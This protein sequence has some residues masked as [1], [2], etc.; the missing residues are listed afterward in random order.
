MSSTHRSSSPP[1]TPSSDTPQPDLRVG[2]TKEAKRERRREAHESTLA[3]LGR[4]L[5]HFYQM[6]GSSKAAL[7]QVFEV[8]DLE[9]DPLERR[10]GSS[11]FDPQ[12]ATLL[13]WMLSSC[14]SLS[15]M[16]EDAASDPD[17]SAA[18]SKLA[19]PIDQGWG[20]ARNT[21]TAALKSAVAANF[22][23]EPG[24]DE[25]GDWT[26]RL[27]VTGKDNWGL[28]HPQLSVLMTPVQDPPLTDED[29]AK[30]RQPGCLVPHD[31]WYPWMWKGRTVDPSDP[32][33]GFLR[34]DLLTKAWRVIYFG[35]A[36]VPMRHRIN[37]AKEM[38]FSRTTTHSIAYIATLM[39]FVL[40]NERR[41]DFGFDSLGFYRELLRFLRHPDQTEF[42]SNLLLWWDE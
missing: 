8:E 6:Y 7:L 17:P 41:I 4:N 9:S 26:P 1:N 21:D 31:K 20:E 29:I 15:P 35:S 10:L 36:L 34:G 11:N 3:S 27:I 12:L 38:G 39:R 19:R 32:E 22:N 2:M 33:C 28:N 30:L 23:L 5:G 40:S 14:P 24:A 25:F 37:A 42:T 13:K 16:L 18:L